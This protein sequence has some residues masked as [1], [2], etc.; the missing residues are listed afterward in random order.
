[1]TIPKRAG[2]EGGKKLKS[3]NEKAIPGVVGH[4]GDFQKK[5]GHHERGTKGGKCTLPAS[6]PGPVSEGVIKSRER[7]WLGHWG[8]TPLNQMMSE[9]SRRTARLR[10]LAIKGARCERKRERMKRDSSWRAGKS[11][12]VSGQRFRWRWAAR[13]WI[14]MPAGLGCGAQAR[15]FAK[16]PRVV[17]RKTTIG[18][19]INV[20]SIRGGGELPS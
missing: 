6:G 3:T 4:L 2:R 7:F 8:K 17:L 11:G 14:L 20:I 18:S 19:A 9:Q 15:R 12:E 1:L 13:E 16:S 5:E 10:T